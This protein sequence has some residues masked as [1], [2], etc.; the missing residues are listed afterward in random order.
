MCHGFDIGTHEGGV[1]YLGDK[2]YQI[3]TQIG[4]GGG[5]GCCCFTQINIYKYN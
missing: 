3:A 4:G 1:P 2:N 5:G